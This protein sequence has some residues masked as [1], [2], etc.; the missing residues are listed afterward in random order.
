MSKQEKHQQY[1]LASSFSTLFL[2]SYFPRV[3]DTLLRRVLPSMPRVTPRC[4]T[5]SQVPCLKLNCGGKSQVC[6]QQ[7]RRNEP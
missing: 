1:I 3:L 7:H 5:P 2:T 4:A 6:N